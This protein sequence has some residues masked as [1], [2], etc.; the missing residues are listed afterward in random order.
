VT[1][2]G[3]RASTRGAGRDPAGTAAGSAI[4]SDPDE[5]RRLIEQLRGAAGFRVDGP[6]GR[7][8][9]LQGFDPGDAG[10]P[11]HIRVSIGLFIVKVVPISIADVV[12]ADLSRRR[13]HVRVIP[14]ERR[15]PGQALARRVRRFVR[16][17]RP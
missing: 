14:P 1:A 6:E 4:V 10:K 16:S 8:G 15:V 7:I 12:R 17:R 13:V 2:T 3:T 5:R 9:I 11:G